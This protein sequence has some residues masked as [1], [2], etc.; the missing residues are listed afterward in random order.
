MATLSGPLA[1]PRL[2]RRLQRLARV[3][4]VLLVVG[5][6][7]LVG[8]EAW[9]WSTPEHALE[10]LRRRSDVQP[11][12]LTPDVRLLAALVSLV[13]LAIALMAIWRLWGVF[14]EYGQGRVFSRRAL[15]CLRGFARWLMA[16]AL[17]SP[18]YG[19]ALSVIVSWNHGPGKRTLSLEV[20]SDDYAQLV[21]GFVVLAICTVMAEAA[22]VAEDNEGFV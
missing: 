13:P 11:A 16:N 9:A 18:L 1:D 7:F 14:A 21:F 8:G 15:T 5:A 20:S 19:A 6:I 4:H 17:V 12:Q 3:V 10:I 22:R 2:H